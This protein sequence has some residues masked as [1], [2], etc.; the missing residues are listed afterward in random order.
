M[1]IFTNDYIK[2]Q[3]KRVL[4]KNCL[5]KAKNGHKLLRET[6]LQSHLRVSCEAQY[7]HLSHFIA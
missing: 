6:V 7:I 5:N 1:G 2:Q 4:R 3:D